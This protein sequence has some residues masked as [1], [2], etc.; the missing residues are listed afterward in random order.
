MF[1]RGKFYNVYCNTN[2]RIYFTFKN[3]FQIEKKNWDKIGHFGCTREKLQNSSWC[4]I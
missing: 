1:F 3:F 4:E 2:V